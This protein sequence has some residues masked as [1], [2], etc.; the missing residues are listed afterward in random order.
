MLAYPTDEDNDAAD[1]AE[2]SQE[3]MTELLALSS[4]KF[5]DGIANMIKFVMENKKKPTTVLSAMLGASTS[6]TE[7]SLLLEDNTP[8]NLE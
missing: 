6:S 7:Q 2:D 4:D 1:D 3:D 8:F 5:A